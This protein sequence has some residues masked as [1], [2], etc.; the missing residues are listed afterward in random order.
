MDAEVVLRQPNIAELVLRA[1]GSRERGLGFVNGRVEPSEPLVELLFLF[2]QSGVSVDD[3][4]HQEP[5][6]RRLSGHG[7][8]ASLG[9]NWL[10]SNKPETPVSVSVKFFFFK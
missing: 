4:R 6:A 10:V 5:A 3:N 7:Y 1:P 8:D 2:V 9:K